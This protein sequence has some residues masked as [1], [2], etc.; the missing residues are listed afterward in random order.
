[1]DHD[2]HMGIEGMTMETYQK[3]VALIRSAINH[4]TGISHLT[5][6]VGQSSLSCCIKSDSNLNPPGF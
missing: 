4:P 6:K 5:L 2:S 1:M 3:I